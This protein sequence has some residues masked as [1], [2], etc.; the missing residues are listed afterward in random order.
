ML[1]KRPKFNDI[2]EHILK[3]IDIHNIVII[4]LERDKI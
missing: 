4:C 2:L 3:H 1:N